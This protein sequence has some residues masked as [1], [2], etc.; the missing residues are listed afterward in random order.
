M[1]NNRL[2]LIDGNSIM[3]RAFYGIMGSKMLTAIDGT[4]T[5]AVYGFLNI[6][7]KIM[8]NLEPEYMVVTFDLK[9]PTE[10]HR[11]Y[12]GYKANRKGMPNELA[13]QMPIIK[14]ILRKMNITIIEKEGYE[15]DDVL[16]TLSKRA[17]RKGLNVTILSGDR[18]TFQLATD[19]ITIRIPRTKF[20]K[21]E[22]E[23]FDRNKV[24]E[25]Y[26]IEPKQ[27]IELKGLMGDSSDNIPGVVGVGEKTA[28]TLIKKYK[29]I[30]NLYKNL[31]EG[32]TDI[33]GRLLE[34]LTENKDLADLSKILGT[35]NLKVPIDEKIE[36]FRLGEWKNEEVLEIFKELRFNRFLERFEFDEKKE[37][38]DIETLFKLKEIQEDK[39]VEALEKI[40]SLKEF[41]FYLVFE[42]DDLDEK[43]INKRVKSVNIY[44]LENNIVY[45]IMLNKHEN[46]QKFKEIFEDEKIAKNGYNLEKDL[47]I[48]RQE[49]IN[50]R[51]IVFDAE[52]AAYLL[53]PS[54]SKYPIGELSLKYLSIDVETYI[55]IEKNENEAQ[56]NM[57]DMID[58]QKKADNTKRLGIIY[59]YIIGNLKKVMLERLDEIESRELFEK[60]EM[61]LIEVLADMQYNGIYVNKEELINFGGKIKEDLEKTTKE[62][63]RL[64]GEEFNL[65]STQQL[66]KILF[67][68]LK[69]TV[70]KKTKKGY[71]TDVAVLEKLK[72]EHEIIEKILHYRAL[73]KLN[74]TYVEGLIPYINKKTGKIHS[75]FNQ[76]ITSTGRISSSEPNLQN[77]PTKLEQG[78]LLRKAF[79]PQEGNIFID[80][81]YS[82]IELRVMAHIAKDENMIKDFNNNIDI[83]TQVASKILDIPVSEVTKQQRSSAKTVNFGIVYGISDFGLGEQLGIN[84]KKAK[85]YIEQYLKKYNGV[86]QFMTDIVEEAKEKGYVETLFKRRRYIPEITSNNYMIRQFGARAAMNT[87]IQGTAADIMKIAMINLYKKLKEENLRG[88]IILQVHDELMLEVKIEDKERVK[89]ILSQSMKQA[90]NLLVPLEVELSEAENW[91]EAK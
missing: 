34:R 85:E 24:K 79:K 48:L 75:T 5:N 70:Y 44:D 18:D 12:E 23:D 57:F 10:R 4:P 11:M 62:I 77:I 73:A 80:A 71:A 32:K 6:M 17:A 16:G 64:A 38:T 67:E 41:S 13:Q 83:H 84:R 89:Q 2:V 28:L 31:E 49:N 42:Q 3:N 53:N 39:I 14:D 47:V 50:I 91:Y 59:S 81:D 36:D 27:M 82:Q 25:V 87:P 7:F 78:K 55:K 40:K 63:Y 56:I 19:K 22:E 8:E 37:K 58:E 43:I 51:N 88:K 46:I 33:K 60:V 21:T 1:D 26:G 66:G 35:I 54:D 90:A 9:A 76:T 74:S 45:Y 69:L 20:G 29:T 86:K 52:V 72:G 30:E 65:N 15:A 61:P 68:N